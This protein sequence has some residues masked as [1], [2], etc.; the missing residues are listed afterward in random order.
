MLYNC[1]TKYGQEYFKNHLEMYLKYIKI[2]SKIRQNSDKN[3]P[4]F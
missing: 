1:L 2:L 3:P 4:E